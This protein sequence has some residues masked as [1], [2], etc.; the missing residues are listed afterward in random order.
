MSSLENISF[1][2]AKPEDAN[3]LFEVK[4]AA[5]GDEF[6]LFDYGKDERYKESVEDCHVDKAKDEGMFSR[7]W[8]EAFCSPFGDWTLA[9]EADTKVIGSI[10]AQPGRYFKN[11]YPEY[12]MSEDVNVLFCVYVLPEYKNK[13]IGCKAIEYMEK[14]HPAGKWILDTPDISWKNKHFYEKCGYKKGESRNK[15]VYVKG[16]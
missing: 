12:D 4:I 16:F 15:N 8:H 7:K 13:G 14:L 6:K 1:R 3:V 11:E 5:Y 2:P 10:C 9:M